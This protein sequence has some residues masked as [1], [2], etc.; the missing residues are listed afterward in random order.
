MSRYG[1][2]KYKCQKTSNYPINGQTHDAVRPFLPP[3]DQKLP[4]LDAKL[5][6]F[7]YVGTVTNIQ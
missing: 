6:S 2:E 7:H 3:N 4:K 1:V 5:W